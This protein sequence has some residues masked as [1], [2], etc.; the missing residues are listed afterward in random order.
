[1]AALTPFCVGSIIL[2]C[3]SLSQFAIA[4]GSETYAVTGVPLKK[5]RPCLITY[6]DE[7]NVYVAPLTGAVY[8]AIVKGGSLE[9]TMQEGVSVHFSICSCAT[10]DFLCSTL[11]VLKRLVVTS[12]VQQQCAESC[13]PN[14]SYQLSSI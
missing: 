6:I 1:M 9:L 7:N 2:A 4:S 3:T 8:H 11:T 5:K 10:T 12:S 14:E 13:N